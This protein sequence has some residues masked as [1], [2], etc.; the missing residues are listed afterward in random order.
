MVAIQF[1]QVSAEFCMLS[2]TGE[3]VCRRI[4]CL[5]HDGFVEKMQRN[6]H[7]HRYSYIVAA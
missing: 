1:V 7:H 2:R 4:G 3:G 5:A 6:S